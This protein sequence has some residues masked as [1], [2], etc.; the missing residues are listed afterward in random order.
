MTAV[1]IALAAGVG[2][3]AGLLAIAP[4]AVGEAESAQR[5]G[6]AVVAGAAAAILTLLP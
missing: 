2:V 5:V 6:Y 4:A 3:A 1:L